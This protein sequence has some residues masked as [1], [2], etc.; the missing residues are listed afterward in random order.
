MI[1]RAAA[2]P[3]KVQP[4]RA[5]QPPVWSIGPTIERADIPELCECLEDLLVASDGGVVICDVGTIERPDIVTIELLARLQL[6]AQRLGGGIHLQG[7]R[8]RLRELV[9]LVGLAAA[10][11]LAVEPAPADGPESRER[12][13][14]AQG[15]LQGGR[16][17]ATAARAE[18]AP[19]SAVEPAPADGPES[20]ERS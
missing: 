18:R 10:L 4:S 6:A 14:R 7:A 1:L 11:P 9:A 17:G 5:Q 13:D 16:P 3:T 19:N 15:R 12:S 20:R 2:G 8:P